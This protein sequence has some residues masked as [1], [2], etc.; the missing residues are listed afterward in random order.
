[1]ASNVTRLQVLGLYKRLLRTG[2]KWQASTGQPQ[3]TQ[4]EQIYIRNETKTLFKNN[5]QVDREQTKDQ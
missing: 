4:D 1:M 2:Q 3:D 5:K